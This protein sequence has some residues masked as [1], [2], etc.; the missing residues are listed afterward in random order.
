[1]ICTNTLKALEDKVSTKPYKWREA[2]QDFQVSETW[3]SFYFFDTDTSVTN[4][5]VA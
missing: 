4:S 2:P 5:F 3:L 1:M